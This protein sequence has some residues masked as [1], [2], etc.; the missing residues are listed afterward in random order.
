M[1]AEAVEAE[2]IRLEKEAAKAERIR[3]L[4]EA[5]EAELEEE[6]EQTG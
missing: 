3:L 4:K 1:E 6:S 2:R 5:L